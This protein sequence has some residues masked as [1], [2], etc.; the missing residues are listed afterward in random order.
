MG[1]R[2]SLLSIKT[3]DTVN[4]LN[5]WTAVICVLCVY[6][7]LTLGIWKLLIE[8][9]PI[10]KTINPK[11]IIEANKNSLLDNFY[12]FDGLGITDPSTN[13]S[14]SINI[15]PSITDMATKCKMFGNDCLGFDTLGSLFLKR[16]QDI[17]TL[18]GL[19]KQYRGGLYIATDGPH[20]N[21]VCEQLG[22]DFDKVNKHC[23]NFNRSAIN[24]YPFPISS[25]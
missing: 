18:K 21:K 9:P 19:K 5:R 10:Q 16:D 4:F 17:S 14:D 3:K 13:F 12:Y 7:I 23:V 11:R 1:L 24:D 22:G 15:T 20:A 2:Q 6:L 8:D 25:L